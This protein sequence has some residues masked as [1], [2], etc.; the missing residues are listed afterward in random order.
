MTWARVDLTGVQP[1]DVPIALAL[2]HR[3]MAVGDA[4]EVELALPPALP[5]GRDDV[6][7][8]AGFTPTGRT[9]VRARTL[10]DTVGLGMQLL[11]CGLNPSLYAA[12]AGVPFARPGNRFWPAAV[13]A[14]MVSRDRDAIHALETHGVGLTD[15]AKRATA[16]ADEL[17][18]AE[19]RDGM[20][21]VGRLVEWLQPGAVCFVGLA[22]WRAVVDRKAVA[23]VQGGD[24]GGRPVYVMPSTSGL[25]AATPLAALA[26]HLSAA[27]ELGRASR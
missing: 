7:T 20:Q 22:G 23:G 8:G 18:P 4:L 13:A 24:I 27:G 3:V 2:R 26:G 25:N 14:S 17:D 16:R 6:L 11:V 15:L 12:D 10:P 21:R 19:Y 9:A 5:I 1:E